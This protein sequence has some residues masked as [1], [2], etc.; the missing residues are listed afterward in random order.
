MNIQI[1]GTKKSS[2]TRKAERF[3][4]ERGI[5]FQSIDLKE[6]GLSKGEFN[7]VMQAV[8]GVDAMIDPDCKD[9][10]LLA[11][12]TYISADERAD[13]VM[14]NQSVIRQPIVRNGR[15]AT[16]GYVPDV[17]MRTVEKI[18]YG[19]ASAVRVPPDEISDLGMPDRFIAFDTETTGLN[20]D[21]DCI[22]ELGAVVFEHGVPIETFQSYVNPGVCI[23]EEVSAL[24]HI[25]NEMLQAAPTEEIIYPEL[26]RFL[27]TA[28][29]GETMMMELKRFITER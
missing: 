4:K 14:E 6:K 27:G 9:K 19:S 18:E 16:V 23:S 13:K 11:L 2:D 20:P 8:G 1:F 7:S 24:N 10:D 17:W 21:K 12:V 3:F 29:K 28:A 26:M 22:V 25:T 15:Q 5:K